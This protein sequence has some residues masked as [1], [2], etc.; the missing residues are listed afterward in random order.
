MFG[1]GRRVMVDKSFEKCNKR[2]EKLIKYFQ[3]E[4]F[5][6]R[7]TM[8]PK[9]ILN[10]LTFIVFLVQVRFELILLSI[11]VFL[12]YDNNCQ[13]VSAADEPNAVQKQ[14]GQLQMLIGKFVQMIS[15]LLKQI[16][17]LELNVKFEILNS[18]SCEKFSFI[19]LSKGP[20]PTAS[21]KRRR[22]STNSASNR[23]ASRQFG[24]VVG[25]E[26]AALKK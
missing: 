3:F 11:R 4:W 12:I 2:H 17:G 16:T 13:F 9:L 14:L 19:Y 6:Y 23:A 22:N 18:L 5:Y 1:E 25:I 26:S 10:F 8:D 7:A 15:G 21:G 24:H 20:S